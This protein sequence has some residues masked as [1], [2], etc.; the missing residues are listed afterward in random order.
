MRIIFLD[1]DGVIATP[2]TLIAYK[3]I[4]WCIDPTK[5][6]MVKRLCE[7][8]DAKLVISSSWK[9]LHTYHT[10]M[11][12]MTAYGLDEYLFCDRTEAASESDEE[13]KQ[14]LWK[15]PNGGKI[16]GEEIDQWIEEFKSRGYELDEWIILDDDSD[17]TQDQLKKHLIQTDGDIGFN[18]KDFYRARNEL[19]YDNTE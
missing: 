7:D 9:T 13:W 4:M 5:A 8:T 2:D 17:F 15:T 14:R 3:K 11:D 16:R 6:L 19:G 10:F 12:L 1:I 18:Y